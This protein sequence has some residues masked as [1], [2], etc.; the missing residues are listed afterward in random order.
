LEQ[1]HYL[2]D[3]YS[4]YKKAAALEPELPVYKSTLESFKKDYAIK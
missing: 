2:A 3:A 4:Y 1:S